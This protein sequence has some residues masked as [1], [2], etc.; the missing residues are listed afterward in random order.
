VR[1]RL[2]QHLQRVTDTAPGE[3]VE[4]VDVE[5]PE[6]P[7]PGILAKPAQLGARH[8]PTP[9]LLLVPGADAV[10]LAAAA[11]W[12]ADLCIAASWELELTRR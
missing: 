5:P 12:I 10:S 8:G 6:Q 4:A 2:F 7:R 9:A 11:R 1:L 3:A